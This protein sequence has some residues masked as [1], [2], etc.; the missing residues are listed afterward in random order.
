[1]EEVGSIKNEVNIQLKWVFW[2]CDWKWFWLKKEKKRR[3]KE[4]EEAEAHGNRG[5]CGED[6]EQFD[7][8]IFGRKSNRE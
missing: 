3:E 1:M 6:S 4:R 7:E 8:L 5:A 2:C